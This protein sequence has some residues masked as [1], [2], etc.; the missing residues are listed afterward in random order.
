MR[1]FMI[2]HK[3]LQADDGRAL[4][5]GK[6]GG[7]SPRDSAKIVWLEDRH[8][9]ALPHDGEWVEVLPET[10]PR[11]ASA[12]IR[13]AIKSMGIETA[14]VTASTVGFTDLARC[15]RI[16]VRV[17][18]WAYDKEKSDTLHSI[19]DSWGFYLDLPDLYV[20]EESV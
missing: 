18:P 7:W 8:T 13:N 10:T 5:W 15:S 12:L 2:V 3:H 19:G 17:R 20:A 9:I 14:K 4:Y 1:R 11:R 6:G 16:F